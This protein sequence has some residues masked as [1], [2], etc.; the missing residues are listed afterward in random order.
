MAARTLVFVLCAASCAVSCAALMAC[1]HDDSAPRG[2]PGKTPSA[3][4]ADAANGGGPRLNDPSLSLDTIDGVQAP[5][6]IA[7]LGADDL[8]VAEKATGRIVRVRNGDVQRDPVVSL[9]ANVADERGVLGL[10]LH[11]Q[12]AQ[13]NYVYV[14][15]TWAGGGQEP[16]ALLGEPSGDIEHVPPLGNRVDRFRWDGSRLNFDR[17]IIR[18]PSR[19]TDLTL[20]RRRGN[21]NGGVIDFGPDGKLYVV[22]GDQNDR[23]PLQNVAFGEQRS[24]IDSLTG[25]VLRLNDDGSTPRDNP[26]VGAVD[27]L[28]LENVFLYG[29][30][31]SY[32]FDWEPRTGAFWIDVAGQASFDQIGTYNPGTN[33]GWLQIVGRPE[34][35]ADFRTIELASDRRLD[36]PSFPPSLLAEDAGDALRRLVLIASS[37]Y[38]PPAFSWRR[39]VVPAALRF[40][41]GAGLGDDYDGALL[42]G[43]MTTGALYRF[44]MTPD[45]KDLLLEAPLKD[46]VN[47]NTGDPIG[48]L[49]ETVFGRGFFGATDIE[50]APD[51]AVWVA[52][53][54]N[55]ALYRIS[56]NED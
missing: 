46:R 2:E 34:R 5:T 28:V 7:F 8:L 19:T 45:G 40:L 30:R 24:G 50:V 42:V 51:G 39:P 23:G 41:A 6:Q 31:N 18:L 48:E 36:N 26:F 54:E 4:G 25:V 21:N 47:D 1:T 15:W 29:L 20:G 35:Y 52:S 17:N 16:E 12:F 27:D 53:L 32:G 49:S 43:D 33:I 44:D 22:I 3:G 13:N 9:K 10:A 55:K 56:A 38:W 14:Y 37:T 11:P